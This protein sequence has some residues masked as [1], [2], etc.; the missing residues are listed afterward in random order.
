MIERQRNVF[1]G[2]L[3]CVFVFTFGCVAELFSQ[4]IV[5][6]DLS[7]ISDATV[8]SV[9]DEGLLLSSG[10]RI[11]WDRILQAEIDDA[12]Q[13]QLNDRIEQ[14]GLP[15]FRIKQRLLVSDF[16]GAFEIAEP[17]YLDGPSLPG[18]A[19]NFL[20]CKSVMM[21]RIESGQY[22]AAVEP[23]LRSV[24][25]QSKCTD[26]SLDSFSHLLFEATE[27][28]TEVCDELLPIWPDVEQ[29]KIELERLMDSDAITRI[30]ESFPAAAIYLASMAAQTEQYD[31]VQRWDQ[32]FRAESL[33]RW[34]VVMQSSFVR[35]SYRRIMSDAEGALRVVAMYL[36][37]TDQNSGEQNA[38]RRVLKLLTIVANYQQQ[39]PVAARISLQAA[40]ELST[41]PLQRQSLQR[42]FERYGR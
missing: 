22:A 19:A 6:R 18:N 36:W 27:L 4:T 21:G 2:F 41:N 8:R 35:N 11:P 13:Q 1:S 32:T 26:G 39:F 17:L 23:M 38:D 25:F 42:E 10:Q 5:L 14:V 24:E 16:S 7:I 9:E 3:S 40:I 31:L 33:R 30:M 20:L 37:A 34:R 29:A 15:L 28:R 12:F